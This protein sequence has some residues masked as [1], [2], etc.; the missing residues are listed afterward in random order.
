MDGVTRYPLTYDKFVSGFFG[1]NVIVTKNA[2]LDTPSVS[3]FPKTQ[4]Y[5]RDMD[6]AYLKVTFSS[7]K[8][9]EIAMSPYNLLPKVNEKHPYSARECLQ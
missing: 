9:E 4:R 6:L 7:D 8:Y 5:Q 2:H 3:L 1:D